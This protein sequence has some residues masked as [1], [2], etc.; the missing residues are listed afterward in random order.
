MQY[1]QTYNDLAISH[2]ICKFHQFIT[3]TC[4]SRLVL[5]GY[6]CYKI[7][8]SQNV[9]SEVQIKNLF[10]SYKNYVLFSKYL[11]FCIFNHTMIYQ[12]CDV[13]MIISTW[14]RVHFWIYLLNQD[15][16]K[17]CQDSSALF[18]KKGEERA[19]KNGKC[20]LL[21]MARSCYIVILIKS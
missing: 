12:N 5:K 16:T 21:K 2:T 4:H 15:C 7:I 19:I 6:L 18:F 17:I 13:M 11:R 1:H 14:D 8:I 3:F 9:S 20:Q 10:I